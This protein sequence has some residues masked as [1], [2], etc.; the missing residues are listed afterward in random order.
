[1]RIIKLFSFTGL[2]VVKNYKLN[3]S[4]SI[5]KKL[6]LEIKKVTKYFRFIF[7]ISF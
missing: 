1:M 4:M 6:K 2:F 7:T 5:V 3:G